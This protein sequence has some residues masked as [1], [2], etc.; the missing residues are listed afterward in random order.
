MSPSDGEHMTKRNRLAPELVDGRQSPAALDI[1]RGARR[2]LLSRGL[3][4]LTEVSLANGRRADILALAEQGEL[5][6]IEIKSSVE[7]FRAD[8]KWQQYREYCD[9]L[10][11]AVDTS[12]PQGLLPVDTGLIVADRFGG[13]I[14][15]EAPVHPLAAARRKALTTRIARV[16]ALRLLALAD[17]ELRLEREAL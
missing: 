11:F 16:G 7:D 13:E 6:I 4:S 1:A 12:F 5:W 15:R 3:A 14:L 2:L 9:R 8:H 17:P 10:F